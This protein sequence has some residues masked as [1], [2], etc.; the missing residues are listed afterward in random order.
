MF[1]PKQGNRGHEGRHKEQQ[2]ANGKRKTLVSVRT[3]MLTR[4]SS[5][6]HIKE[7]HQD[8]ESWIFRSLAL[9]VGGCACVMQLQ[10]SSRLRATQ[11][12]TFFLYEG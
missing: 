8:H 9:Y 3:E 4:R 5:T 1:V 6:E 11:R 7:Y 12:A 2:E 10:H